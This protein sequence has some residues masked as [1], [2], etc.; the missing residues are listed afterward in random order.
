[1]HKYADIELELSPDLPPISGNAQKM[2]QVII[3]LMINAAQAMKEDVRGLITVAT[4]WDNGNAVIEVKDNGAGMSERTMK[5]IF[6]P[7]FTTRRA[8]GGTG[9]GL[10]IVFRIVEE[11]RGAISVT[12]K[13]DAGTVFTIKMP[14]RGEEMK[15]DRREAPLAA[16]A[17]SAAGGNGGA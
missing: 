4:R 9:L 16:A 5:N 10:P 17:A 1:M 8:K 11:H 13:L 15:G 3:N 12:S 6:D 7:F 2:E 14:L